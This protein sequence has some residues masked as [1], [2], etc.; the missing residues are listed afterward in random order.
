M[1]ITYSYSAY[2]WHLKGNQGN[3]YKEGVENNKTMQF[4]V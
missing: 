4:I 3:G 1:K 2:I